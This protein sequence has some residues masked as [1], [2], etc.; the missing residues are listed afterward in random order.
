MVRLKGFC[1][2]NGLS[3]QEIMLFRLLLEE[4]LLSIKQHGFPSD[5]P[6]S[7]DVRIIILRM[8]T[9][10]AVHYKSTFGVNNLTVIIDQSHTDA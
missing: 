7:M 1:V 2:G 9:A 8:Q 5:A 3:R 10:D 4:M 6:A